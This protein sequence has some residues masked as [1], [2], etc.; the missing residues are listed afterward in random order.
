[1]VS[2]PTE[3]PAN[4][5]QQLNQ[6]PWMLP[7]G[8][9][10]GAVTGFTY[11]TLMPA[12]MGY[13]RGLNN[14]NASGAATATVSTI[15]DPNG[16]GQAVQIAATFTQANE[17]IQLDWFLDI[18]GVLAGDQYYANMRVDVASG[19]AN[20]CICYHRLAFTPDGNGALV[21]FAYDM[22]G[23]PS[24]AADW[25]PGPTTAYSLVS[26]ETGIVTVPAF[27][28]SL[29]GAQ[30]I[31]LGSSGGAGN[32]TVTISRAGVRKVMN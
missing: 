2:S 13:T 19:S 23:D 18:T 15:T 5:R 9:T 25:G 17:F 11:A 4:G 8:S 31:R 26:S 14:T 3:I 22:Y 29:A 7:N 20:G 6:L 32:I 16:F 12:N 24:Q 27:N 30:R 21:A 1:L 10:P 28:T